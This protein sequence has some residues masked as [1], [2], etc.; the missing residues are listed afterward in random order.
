MKFP[1]FIRRSA[2]IIASLCMLALSSCQTPR[3]AENESSA[4]RFEPIE[5]EVAKPQVVRDLDEI[6]SNGTLRVLLRNSS[7]SYHILRGQEYGFE[8]ELAAALARSLNVRLEVVLP[9]SES[10]VRSQL[11]R[12]DVD[13]IAMPLE[14]PKKGP[15]YVAY[16]APYNDV[17]LVVVSHGSEA[18]SLRS[19]ADLEGIMVAARHWS[20]EESAL[21][22]L[23]RSGLNVGIV[24][25][26][27]G[28]SEEEILEFVADGTY[29]AAVVHSDVA[30]AVQ[31]YRQE[32][33]IAFELEASESVRWAVRNNNPKL[34][35][36][37][38]QFL[39][40]HRKETPDGRVSHSRLYNILTK[41]YFSD[42][43]LIRSRVEDP[44]HLARTGRL[45]P[46]DEL[47]AESAVR[48]GF[49]WRLIA[50]ISFQESRFDPDAISW[51][52]AVG[53]MQ[54]RPRTAGRD[55]NDLADA[56]LNVELGVKHLASLYRLYRFLD[57]ETRLKF[58]LAAYNC[59][60]GHLDDARL[61]CMNR[62]RDPNDWDNVQEALLL[63]RQPEYHRQV[64]YGF[65][66]GTETVRYVAHVLQRYE[67]FK[68]ILD[69]TPLL[70][71]A[72]NV[73]SPTGAD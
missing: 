53:L 61:I 10:S 33:E 21:L 34:L 27:S 49:D 14:A 1:V 11:N 25:F 3:N 26:G 7:S 41:K 5:P 16:T 44:F 35:E 64:R 59:G 9:D 56:S 57:D 17:Q 32:L 73:P 6:Q 30:R 13:V 37:V 72:M 18:D 58:A 48:H 54:L 45:S 71:T 52:G 60:Q 39:G 66:R 24:M 15:A 42:S 46:Y 2:A 63:L 40:L 19:V 69:E 23:R 51:A 22:E 62:G 12:G 50:S 4:L 20:R 65:V 43:R 8:Y 28:S 36:S 47:F 38:N 55:A 68:K 67:L 31:S 29:S 70:K